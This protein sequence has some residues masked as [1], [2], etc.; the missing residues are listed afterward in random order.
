M[1]NLIPFAFAALV[2]ILVFAVVGTR[3]SHALYAG[4]ASAAVAQAPAMPKVEVLRADT[5]V[6]DGRHLR[7]A[8]ATTPQP[9]PFAHCAAEA[10]AAR[11]AELRL[12]SIALHAHNIAVTPI[13]VSDAEGRTS[14]HL[15]IDGVDPA[16]VLIDEGLAVAPQQAGFDWCAPASTTLPAVQHIAM[17]SFSG[18]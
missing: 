14:A 13:G 12:Q 7:L 11:Q 18:R 6:V 9:A 17:L 1:K 15:I 16:Q 3:P 2:A 5:L 10:M 4:A 8:D